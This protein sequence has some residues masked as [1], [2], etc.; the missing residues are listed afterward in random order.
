MIETFVRFIDWY[1]DHGFMK[2]SLQKLYTSW[3][4][5]SMH[6]CVYA[7]RFTQEDKSSLVVIKWFE[8]DII[9]FCVLNINRIWLNFTIYKGLDIKMKNWP[10]HF[11][12][13][14]INGP[15]LLI[16]QIMIYNWLL[17]LGLS[18]QILYLPI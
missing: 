11:Q 9:H 8:T 18:K 7:M 17:H 10:Q 15:G 16:I 4:Y 12:I 1:T 2:I 3:I 6:R 13:S 14:L 5:E